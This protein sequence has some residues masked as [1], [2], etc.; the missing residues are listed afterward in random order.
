MTLINKFIIIFLNIFSYKETIFE[1]SLEITQDE[2]A[3]L[4]DILSDAQFGI[5]LNESKELK[6]SESIEPNDDENDPEER[7]LDPIHPTV[8][9]TTT[10]LL[11]NICLGVI[12]AVDYHTNQTLWK[13]LLIIIQPLLHIYYQWYQRLFNE[14]VNDLLLSKAEEQGDNY[15]ISF[16]PTTIT[17]TILDD[18]QVLSE[19]ITE[20]ISEDIIITPSNNNQTIEMIVDQIAFTIE[21]TIVEGSNSP[22]LSE[23]DNN[24][25]NI[26][27]TTDNNS[28]I[29]STSFNVLFC[30]GLIFLL[31]LLTR[32]LGHYQHQKNISKHKLYK[33]SQNNDNN[34]NNNQHYYQ[35]TEE[36]NNHNNNHNNEHH[37]NLRSLDKKHENN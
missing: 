26:I 10:F 36:E 24:N 3:N 20:V 6:N 23:K 33:Q 19:A 32:V 7:I 2:I 12:L 4:T 29:S 18:N 25:N 16:T 28:M 30:F 22:S 9:R 15:D 34:N 13:Y 31:Y 14:S 21:T 1:D 17:T 5:E 27:N 11:I 37:Y 8:H 35:E